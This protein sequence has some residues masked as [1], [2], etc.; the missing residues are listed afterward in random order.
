MDLG[1][2]QDFTYQIWP[3]RGAMPAFALRATGAGPHYYRQ[4]VHI[5]EGGQGYDLA[6]YTQEQVIGEILDQYE[7]HMFFLHTQREMSG[8]E[9]RMPD[10][11]A[12]A[13]R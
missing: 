1:G 9:T 7:R 11:S 2:E 13:G 3:R 12:T 6:G 5:G 10:D 8:R 4:E